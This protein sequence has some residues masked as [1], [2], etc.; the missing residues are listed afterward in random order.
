MPPRLDRGHVMCRLLAWIWYMNDTMG[1]LH[2]VVM[3]MYYHL[4][5]HY[6]KWPW[7]C[8]RGRIA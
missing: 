3:C 2:I 1:L 5:L 7:W 6:P 8:H 4:Y